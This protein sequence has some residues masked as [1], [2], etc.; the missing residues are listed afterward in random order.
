[1][2]L[3]YLEA[4]ETLNLRLI[5]T[6][7]LILSEVSSGVMFT[8]A[9][10]ASIVGIAAVILQDQGRGLQQV[11]YMARELNLGECGSTSDACC[12]KALAVCEG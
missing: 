12:L 6:P 4:F 1:M 9:I 3:A 2:T 10:A 5:S 7:C 11:S 8:V